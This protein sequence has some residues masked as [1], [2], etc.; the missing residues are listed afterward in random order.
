MPDCDDSTR[1][2]TPKA[3]KNLVAIIAELLILDERLGTVAKTIA[4]EP[5]EVLPA[6]LQAGVECVRADLITD[7]ISTLS[8]LSVLTEADALRRRVEIADAVEHVA[9][10][11]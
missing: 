9:A 8:A 10:F 7:A 2:T 3:Q 11:G 5:E 6:E 4:W 1:L